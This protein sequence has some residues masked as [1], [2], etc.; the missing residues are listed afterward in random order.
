MH[1]SPAT[2]PQAI[3][4]LQWAADQEISTA[5][6]EEMKDHGM[7]PDI[8][9]AD[10]TEVDRIAL[11]Q[12]L[13]IRKIV[14]VPVHRNDWSFNQLLERA[15]Y[16]STE[17]D[18][19]GPVGKFEHCT[20]F[21]HTQ[22]DTEIHLI[23]Y[24][25]LLTRKQ[26]RMKLRSWNLRPADIVEHMSVEFA[27][28]EVVREFNFVCLGSWIE[29]RCEGAKEYEGPVPHYPT[30]FGAIESH[31]RLA[32]HEPPKDGYPCDYYFSAVPVQ[33]KVNP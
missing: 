9:L 11:Q 14:K 6:F 1:E 22:G 26:V 23:R 17:L 2:L 20:P 10:P 33:G 18:G 19:H 21:A 28:P 27:P 24:R 12:F 25:K 4:L 7:L 31:R 30:T 5:D 13:G 3:K 16:Y 29:K 8:F 15:G 32:L